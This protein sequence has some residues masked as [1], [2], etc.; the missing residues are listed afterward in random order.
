MAQSDDRSVFFKF[1]VAELEA[2][3][4][5]MDAYVKRNRATSQ[6]DFEANPDPSFESADKTIRRSLDAL[7]QPPRD[8]YGKASALALEIEAAVDDYGLRGGKWEACQAI[9]RRAT[10]DLLALPQ[11]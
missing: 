10:S 6:S 1:S 4:R 5:A 8:R 2:I 9:V 11:F 7:E 3:K